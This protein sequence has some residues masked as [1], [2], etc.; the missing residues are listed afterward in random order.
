MPFAG[1]NVVIPIEDVLSVKTG[2]PCI[3]R[4]AL[5]VAYRNGQQAARGGASI[6]LQVSPD[7]QSGML[8]IPGLA[9]WL[10]TGPMRIVVLVRLV[11]A[12]AAGPGHLVTKTLLRDTGCDSLDGLFGSDSR[13]RNYIE[14]VAGTRAWR[15]RVEAV[16]SSGD[17]GEASEDQS[18]SQ[19]EDRA[20]VME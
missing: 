15:L 3:D 16:T 2:R 6:A 19:T 4:D 13:W 12:H 20:D 9:P 14:R 1:T 8:T 5:E 10:V 17:D 18:D 7:R 11:Q